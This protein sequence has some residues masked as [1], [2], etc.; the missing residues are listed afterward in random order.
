MP[1]KF[2]VVTLCTDDKIE[3]WDVTKASKV[4]EFK[5]QSTMSAEDFYAHMKKVRSSLCLAHPSLFFISCNL[6]L[7]SCGKATLIL[8]LRSFKPRLIFLPG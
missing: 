3:L 6:R 4:E 1:D 2:H 5:N 7:R 8:S